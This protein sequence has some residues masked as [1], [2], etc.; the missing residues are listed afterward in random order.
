MKRHV[1][2]LAVNEGQNVRDMRMA[3]LSARPILVAGGALLLMMMGGC[4]RLREHQGFI[5]EPLIVASV[6]PGIDNKQSV[7]G[8]MG[9]PTFASQF[10][11]E[12]WYYISRTTRQY[13]FS[14]PRP[15]TQVMYVVEFDKAGNVAKV[16]GDVTLKNVANI[17]PTGDKTPTLG[18]KRSI[19]DEVFGNIGAVGAGGLGGGQ[20]EG[21]Q[22]PNGGGGGGG[23]GGGR[24]QGPNGG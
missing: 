11:P 8:S 9:R 10:G 17:N 19:F 6:L 4:S 14:N 1:G 12:R 3:R 22:G 15:E 7:E 21:G 2:R 18:R 13:A 23:G 5:A 16:N 20:D 24:G